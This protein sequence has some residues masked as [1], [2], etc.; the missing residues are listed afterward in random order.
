M[1]LSHN[2][3]TRCSPQRE[4][5]AEQ[6][7]RAVWNAHRQAEGPSVETVAN[8]KHL[9][10]EAAARHARSPVRGMVSMLMGSWQ[11]IA[12]VAACLLIAA[13]GFYFRSG[14]TTRHVLWNELAAVESEMI[15]EL[16][17][18]EAT[19]WDALAELEADAPTNDLLLH[20]LALQMKIWEDM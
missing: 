14:K 7:M 18:L 20:T 3:I 17:A 4:D 15:R 9:L 10:R 16:H 11:S 5:V 8:V 2:E 13:G 12:A 1:N 19:V 6:A